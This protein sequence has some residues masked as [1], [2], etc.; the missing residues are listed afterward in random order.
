MKTDNETE[1]IMRE[2]IKL[3]GT[4]VKILNTN[5]CGSC[6]LVGHT[7]FSC[8]ANMKIKLVHLRQNRLFKS[9]II[10]LEI[11]KIK[12]EAIETHGINSLTIELETTDDT[13]V[14]TPSLKV[15]KK[16]KVDTHEE[17]FQEQVG[18]K[19]KTLKS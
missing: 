13:S 2:S 9:E 18:K 7:A 19:E 12:K 4:S 3:G 10:P 15:K 5:F 16:R 6:L 11:N 17:E 8:I 14:A 1:V